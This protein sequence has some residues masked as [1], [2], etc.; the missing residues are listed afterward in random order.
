M[1][2][3]TKIA[4]VC[5]SAAVLV[6]VAVA[7]WIVNEPAAPSSP[8]PPGAVTQGLQE[9]VADEVTL[10]LHA[11]NADTVTWTCPAGAGKVKTCGPARVPAGGVWTE[12]VEM[13][14]G[15]TVRVRTVGGVLSPSCSIADAK[16]QRLVHEN[17]ECEWVTG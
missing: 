3:A 14:A 13:P 1:S 8:A 6:G 4:L 16:D 10:Y 15:T 2:K 11:V 7:A 12:K 9:Q 5:V 17:G